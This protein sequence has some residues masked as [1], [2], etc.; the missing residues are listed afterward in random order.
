MQYPPY[1][2]TDPET[3]AYENS[4]E[5]TKTTCTIIAAVVVI[6]SAMLAIGLGVGL[7]VGLKPKSNVQNSTTV[8]PVA[9]FSSVANCVY[10]SSTCGCAAT[11]PSIQATKIINGYPAVANSWPWMVSIY[12]GGQFS[13]G[14]F[15]SQSYQFVITAAHCLVGVSQRSILIYAGLYNQSLRASAQSRS[16]ANW[17]THPN[18]SGLPLYKND[19]AVIKL[20]DS[21]IANQNVSLCCLP[22]SATQLP[23]L[24]EFSVIAGW[25]TTVSGDPSSLSDIL[26][27]TVV[28]IHGVSTF[29]DATATSDIQFCA[30][31]GTS[32]SCQGDSGG[33]LMTVV[34]NSWTCT[35]IVS[36]GNEGCGH[37]GYYTRVSTYRS[38][39]DQQI[40][41]L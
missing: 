22:S 13:C 33:P 34:N 39:I 24:D 27:Q 19:I 30:G 36:Y 8:S 21:F 40:A 1:M 26:L 38:F 16:V 20:N 3:F 25:G 35:G 10:S 41:S 4:S 28:Q 17:T 5:S 2:Y 6:F 37:D 9:T 14:G 18:Y 11:K 15:L 29:C 7:S 32:D 12:Q 31:Y 23:I